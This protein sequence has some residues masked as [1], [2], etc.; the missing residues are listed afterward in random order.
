MSARDGH[1]VCVCVYS[2]TYTYIY[3]YV[4]VYVYIYIYIY[5]FFLSRIVARAGVVRVATNFHCATQI[6]RRVRLTTA[7]PINDDEPGASVAPEQQ[8]QAAA[9]SLGAPGCGERE[10][11]RRKSGSSGSCSTPPPR[12]PRHSKRG[13]GPWQKWQG[14]CWWC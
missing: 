14:R 3:I 5:S 11:A 12:Y 10:A 7:Y 9:G 2:Y 8:E 4:Y 13:D 1:C 6:L